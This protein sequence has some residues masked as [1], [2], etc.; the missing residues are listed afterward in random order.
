MYNEKGGEW[1]VMIG[2]KGFF[3]KFASLLAGASLIIFFLLGTIFIFGLILMQTEKLPVED[4]LYLAFMTSLTVS[5]GNSAITSVLGKLVGVLLG[6]IGLLLMGIIVAAS[7]KAME[8]EAR[9]GG[10]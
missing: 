2:V 5:Y 8:K 3:K 7:I 4:A 1:F 9:S 6:M 10:D